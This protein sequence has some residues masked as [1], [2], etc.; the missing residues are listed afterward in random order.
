MVRKL[1]ILGIAG[2]LLCAMAMAQA[3]KPQAPSSAKPKAPAATKPAQ[4][5]ASATPAPSPAAKPAGD[6]VPAT[7]PVI[8]MKGLC[9][10]ATEGLAKPAP[11]STKD[12]CVAVISKADFEKLLQTLNPALPAAMR[13]NVAK[14]LV[15]LLTM[16]QA[17]E[18][19]GTQ[20]Q[21]NFAEI[22]K[23]QKLSILGSLYNRS[24]DE[25]YRNP[26]QTEIDAYY[27]SHVAQFEEVKLQRIYVPKV[28]P[29]GKSNAPEQK[30]AWVAKAQQVAD[31]MNNRAAKGD[32]VTA[33]QKEAYT[34]L[35]I[36]TNPPNVDIGGVRKGAIAPESE[37]AIA[38]LKAGGVYKSDEP[39][40]IVIYKVLSKQTLPE[41]AVKEEISRTL[42]GEKMQGRRKEISDSVKADFDDKYFG[43][44]APAPA[45]GAAGPR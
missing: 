6:E 8:T 45:P 30:E 27:K 39:S 4:P 41:E 31:D 12:A 33:L 38:L 13:R 23:V 29:S 43:P 19:A 18:K 22:L 9:A 17:A 36:T 3:A 10:D 1:M 5:A 26:P 20:N 35:G 11:G 42:H 32:D 21:P 24:L 14:Q 44:A 40:A 7:T 2:A 25:Q 16:A 15:E 28:D 37:K 34:T